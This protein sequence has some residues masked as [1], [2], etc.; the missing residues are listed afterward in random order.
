MKNKVGLD[1]IEGVIK[2]EKHPEVV[3]LTGE[4]MDNMRISTAFEER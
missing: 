2:A 4:G 1:G 3:V